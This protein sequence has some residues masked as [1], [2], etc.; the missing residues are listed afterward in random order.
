VRVIMPEALA[1]DVSSTPPVF[2]TRL[3]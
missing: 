2:E 3:A 1:G